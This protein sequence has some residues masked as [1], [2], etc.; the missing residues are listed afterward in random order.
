MLWQRLFLTDSEL[1]WPVSLPVTEQYSGFE[2][3]PKQRVSFLVNSGNT[4]LTSCSD[5]ADSATV[6]TV[7]YVTLDHPVC[8]SRIPPPESAKVSKHKMNL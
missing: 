8:H 5:S 3:S 6:S 7:I 2:K 4:E 1:F